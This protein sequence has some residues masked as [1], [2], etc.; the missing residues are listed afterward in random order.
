L[1][2]EALAEGLKKAQKEGPDHRLHRESGLSERPHR[3]RT[4]APKRTLPFGREKE[5]K[6][7]ARSRETQASLDYLGSVGIGLAAKED[8]GGL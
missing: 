3:C 8:R 6:G 7:I 4:W 5:E 2:Q 1:E